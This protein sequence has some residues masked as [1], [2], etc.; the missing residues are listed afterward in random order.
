MVK[1]AGQGGAGTGSRRHV[2]GLMFYL[3]LRPQD[4]LADACN[5]DI[6]A[7]ALLMEPGRENVCHCGVD[8]GVAAIDAAAEGERVATA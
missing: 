2:P 5:R 7:Q 6:E 8:A 1:A 4:T 3:T